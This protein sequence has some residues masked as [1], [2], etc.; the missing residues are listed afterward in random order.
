MTINRKY[1]EEEVGLRWERRN[2]RGYRVSRKKLH[3]LIISIFCIAG[4]T[5][6]AQSSDWSVLRETME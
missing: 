6:L 2:E 5:V 3:M 4:K 1:G